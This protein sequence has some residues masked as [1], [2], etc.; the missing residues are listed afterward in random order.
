[1]KTKDLA[2][3][4]MFTAFIAVCSYIQ[5]PTPLVPF[6]LQ[7]FA[8]SLTAMMLSFKQAS[9]AI[10][11]YVLL[12]LIGLPVFAGG[13]SG[14][15]AILSPSFGFILGFI[16]MTLTINK[17]YHRLEGP[18]RVVALLCGELILY[19][20]ALPILYLNLKN[21]LNITL[22]MKTLFVSYFLI[23]IPTDTLSMGISYYISE[24]INRN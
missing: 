5:I 22:D 23:F 20:I 6:T 19:V 10:V 15:Q 3:S 9:F 16:P 7:V 2:L 21:F 4:A 13:V 12:G 1:M 8:I 17:V 11:S 24:K 18:K 14:P